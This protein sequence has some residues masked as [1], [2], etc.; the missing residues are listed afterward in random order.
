M[1]SSDLD[2]SD[3]VLKYS[4]KKAKSFDTID[5][6]SKVKKLLKKKTY[7]TLQVLVW[8]CLSWRK[9]GEGFLWDQI[10]KIEYLL[11]AYSVQGTVIGWC[12]EVMRKKNL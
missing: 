1:S 11:S 8:R 7:D 3:T 12:P 6:T 4:S 5:V 9:G 10:N 2:K